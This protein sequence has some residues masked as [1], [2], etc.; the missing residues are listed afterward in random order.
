MLVPKFLVGCATFAQ[1]AAPDKEPEFPDP[2][3]FGQVEAEFWNS[4]HKGNYD[5]IPELIDRYQELYVKNPYHAKAAVRLGFL[6][7]WRLT[8]WQ[9]AQD[10]KPGFID[11]AT[12]CRTYFHEATEMIPDDARY[13]GFYAACEMAEADIHKNERNLR[14][15]YFDMLEAVKDWPQFNGFTAGFVLS[16]LPHTHERYDEGVD[17][18][19]TVIDECVGEKVDRQKIDY[20][21]YFSQI[22]LSGVNRVCDNSAIAPHNFEGFFLNMG[23]MLVKQGRVK[24]AKMVYR[25][26]TYHKD[27]PKWPF[28]KVL[29]KRIE[30]AE[31]N[32]SFFRKE[33]QPPKKP[34]WPVIMFH[35]E[36]ACGAC[37]RAS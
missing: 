19:W 4:F 28:K 8:E 18:Q 34:D 25:Q 21:K 6:H 2:A 5:K 23:D 29:E 15:G 10:F 9:R 33:V 32:V 7:V 3:A 30:D 20:R 24:Q 17:F 35:S 27:Y 11:H 12:L 14:K 36:F 22:D 37:H 13:Y 26:A 31:K 16:K 1:W